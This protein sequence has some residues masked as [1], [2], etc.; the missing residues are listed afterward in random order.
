V[1]DE[2]GLNEHVFYSEL[3]TLQSYECAYTALNGKKKKLKKGDI[4]I[5]DVYSTT[6]VSG[7]KALGLTIP[8]CK[9]F[10]YSHVLKSSQGP[11]FAAMDFNPSQIEQ[12]EVIQYR[13]IVPTNQRLSWND[14]DRESLPFHLHVDST[15]QNGKMFYKF[16]ARAKKGKEQTSESFRVRV[17]VHPKE[18]SPDEYLN[19]WYLGLLKDRSTLDSI[20]KAEIN[21]Y[22]LQ[23]KIDTSNDSSLVTG[24]FNWVKASLDYIDIEN[25][26]GAFQPRNPNLTYFNKKGDCKDMSNLLCAALREWGISANLALSSTLSHPFDLTFPSLSSANHVICVAWMNGKRYFLDPTEKFGFGLVP[27]RQI[28]N[29]GI[30]ITG[31]KPEYMV[32]PKVE[33]S[34][35]TVQ[36]KI[37]LAPKG[38]N[39]E[40]NFNYSS[41]NHAALKNNWA[42]QTKSQSSRYPW[43]EKQ[44]KTVCSGM[45]FQEMEC[46]SRTNGINFSGNVAVRNSKVMDLGSK[47]VLDLAIVPFPHPFKQ[48]PDSGIVLYNGNT[49]SSCCSIIISF[50][51]QVALKSAKSNTFQQGNFTFDWSVEQT[52]STSIEIS[53]S[54]ILDA[55]QIDETNYL[56]Y[57]NLNK[58]IQSFYQ[59]PI[60]YVPQ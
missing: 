42:F 24:L 4:Y 46:S 50:E 58:A 43:L 32:V 27:S 7:T 13:V 12:T 29:R 47:V 17:L 10:T 20:T 44:L 21:A 23:K 39:L 28:Q 14:I 26:L 60:T 11:L 5:H 2:N 54:F 36:W 51:E 31:K 9:D 35:N 38:N 8:P 37:D 33:A 19:F 40:G 1:G 53:Y 30:F 15:K 55:V 56:A 18:Q 3:E 59:H 6:F 52:S 34:Y 22:L 25:G 41:S 57:N 45:D 16:S 48:E 49:L